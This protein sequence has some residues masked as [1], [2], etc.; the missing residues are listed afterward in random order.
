M[1]GRSEMLPQTLSLDLPLTGLIGALTHAL[2]MTEGQ[3]RGHSLR[4]CWIGMAVAKVAGLPESLHEDIYYAIL[5]KDLGCSSNAARICE[6]YLAD[7][8]TLK[9]DYKFVNGS[10]SQ[11][12]R[13]VLSHTGLSHGLAERV[14]AIVHILQNGGEI[15][16]ELIET[17][18]HKGSDIA[19][20]MGFS[21]T[22]CAGIR[23][24]DEH[25]DGSGKPEGLSGTAIP[26]SSQIALMA[27]VADVFQTSTTP[28]AARREI[29]I[30][31]G[32]WFDPALVTAFISASADKQFW[33]DL[34]SPDLERKVYELAPG[35]STRIVTAGM[36]DHIAEGFAEVID[37]KSPYTAGHSERVTI[38]TDMI[39]EAMGY[40]D[41]DR[42]SLKRVALLHDIGKLGVSN[43]ILDKPGKLSDTEWLAMR[44]HPVYSDQILSR[45]TAFRGLTQIA[46]GHHERLDG[47]GYPDGL[48]GKQISME[49]R[50]VTLAD[51]FD[52]LTA[53]RPY[54]AAMPVAKALGIL[55]EDAG[56]GIDPQCLMA[57][58]SVMERLNLDKAA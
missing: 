53:D 57:L 50:I 32:G 26:V 52:A 21:E 34:A 7:D 43:A 12:L 29:S 24:L 31:A 56:T 25:W 11:A 41:E 44:N 22:V 18:C 28:E 17:R 15:T 37:S 49:T 55:R 20:K 13:F 38:Y 39:A 35:R 10:L 54:R 36:L 42:Q 48:S 45:S 19:A 9:R 46:R 1:R 51:I 5:L 47:K 58:E 4:C 14:R 2:D 8:L 40:S 33:E 16:S 3:P 6:L 27:Q 23:S 30:R